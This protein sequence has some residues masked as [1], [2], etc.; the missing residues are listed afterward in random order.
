MSEIYDEYKGLLMNRA[1]AFTS[2][3]GVSEELIHDVVVELMKMKDKTFSLSSLD[4]R[5][6]ILVTL[7]NKCTDRYRKE[8]KII[9]ED[10]GEHEDALASDEP[11]LDEL[12]ITQETYAALYRALDEIDDASRCILELRYILGQSYEEISAN[13]GITKKQVDNR[14]MKAKERLRRSMLKGGAV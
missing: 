13:L 10:I 4:L 1:L 12:I 8:G 5:R 6:Y 14:L 2:D 3:A 9:F 7:R 11:P